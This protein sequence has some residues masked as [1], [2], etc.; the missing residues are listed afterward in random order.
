M[1]K[2]T[3]FMIASSMS[4]W[5]WM[6]RRMAVVAFQ[7]TVM[8]PRRTAISTASS[9]TRWLSSSSSS[10][11]SNADGEAIDSLG[12]KIR[13]RSGGWEDENENDNN[14]DNDDWM[15]A[16]ASTTTRTNTNTNTNTNRRDSGGWKDNNDGDDGD[17]WGA[18]SQNTKGSSSSS[19]GGG[20]GSSGGWEDFD[21]WD[22]QD[23]PTTK[24]R[25]S[26]PQRKSRQNNNYR[27]GEWRNDN[28]NNGPRGGG[29][30]RRRGGG[31]DWG[32]N[33]NDASS[34]GRGGNREGGGGRRNNKVDKSRSINMNALEG[35]G[36]V[37]LYGLSSILNALKSERRDLTTVQEK[38][39]MVFDNDDEETIAEEE[40]SREPPKPQAQFRPYLFVQERK[41]FT[42]RRGQ[43]ADD[44]E[45]VLQLAEE[46]NVPIAEVDKGIL[47]TL[48]GNRPHQVR[49]I[50]T[51]F[52][53]QVIFH[54]FDSVGLTINVFHFAS[55]RVLS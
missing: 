15:N 41:T 21:P 11:S 40:E 36:F 13:R 42:G 20:S 48:S 45:Q 25:Q 38:S 47:N 30:G 46:H 9:T 1:I 24:Q 54:P 52:Y 32:R 16:P 55:S 53:G 28:N 49:T 10:S 3:T 39:A 12:R 43:K 2:T 34:F 51:I 31:G 14:D 17:D 33:N 7:S 18:P 19:G 26:P 4:C 29:G 23:T 6:T 5:M 8:L 35:A 50:L 22:D 27:G 37:H 44:A